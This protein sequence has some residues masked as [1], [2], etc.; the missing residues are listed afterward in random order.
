MNYR[1]IKF[2]KIILDIMFFGGIV[3]FIILPFILKI[4]GKHYSAE[5]WH[6]YLQKQ[7]D[8]KKKM[9]LQYKEVSLWE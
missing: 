3:V 8:I 1:F 2:T 5:F 6:M 4:L 9:I 7:S